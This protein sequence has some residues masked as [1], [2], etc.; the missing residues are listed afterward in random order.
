M[1]N[2]LLISLL[3][4]SVNF[5]FSQEKPDTS[6]NAFTVVQQ[7]PAF[8]GDIN[9]YIS[10]HIEYP[11]SENKAKIT[12]TVYIGFIVERDGSVS[13]VR[14]LKGV[15]NGPHL[16]KEAAKVIAGMPKWSPGIQ[17]GSPVRVSFNI[18]IRFTLLN[19]MTPDTT[20]KG[21]QVF[22]IVQQMPK[23]NGD[24]NKYISDNIY[25]PIREKNSNITGTVYVHFII[26]KDGSVSNVK[27]IKGVPGGPG[28]DEEAV[29]VISSTSNKWSIGMQ[30]GHA[31]RVGYNIP[32][33]FE[34]N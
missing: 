2:K 33:K 13:N 22:T 12:G 18:P 8:K 5:A 14:I 16:N 21:D 7:M 17:N 15:A 28:L 34:L 23:F 24:V 3:L 30:N 19:L 31:V 32:I 9:K 4:L 27:V 25:Y 20:S 29:R 10:D 11:D 6:G 1:K 26:E